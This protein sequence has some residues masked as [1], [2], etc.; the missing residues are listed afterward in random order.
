MISVQTL[1][2]FRIVH[3]NADLQACLSPKTR[4]LSAFLLTRKAQRARKTRIVSVFWPDRSEHEARQSLSTCIWELRKAF[5]A[6]YGEA[7]ADGVQVMG[8]EVCLP[9][10]GPQQVDSL[11]FAD[12]VEGLVRAYAARARGPEHADTKEADLSRFAC[13][14][15]YHGPFLDG[16]E[17]DWVLP[18]RSRLEDLYCRGLKL[19][20]R[21]LARASDIDGAV[22]CAKMILAVDPFQESVQCDLIR[23]LALDGQR[24]AALRQYNQLAD[25][26]KAE[27]G[28]QPLPETAELRRRIVGGQFYDDCALERRRIGISAYACGGPR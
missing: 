1:G 20:M 15:D 6:A 2:G 27:L 21:D 7:K 12:A 24:A 9:C 5:R 3:R 4:E 23:L 8:D 18:E 10:A 14:S 28:V 13:L 22:E 26:L 25:M 17:S 16:Y 11:R 19:K